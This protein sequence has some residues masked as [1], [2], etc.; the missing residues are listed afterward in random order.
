MIPL[1]KITCL[2]IPSQVQPLVV[3]E[4][5]LNFCATFLQATT[6]AHINSLHALSAS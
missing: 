4:L 3:P 5:D 2:P 6:L 1:C